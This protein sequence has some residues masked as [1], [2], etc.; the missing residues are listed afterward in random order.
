MKY[1][2]SIALFVIIAALLLGAL[3]TLVVCYRGHSF[4]GECSTLSELPMFGTSLPTQK[5]GPIEYLAERKHRRV[6]AKVKTT[7]SEFER[8]SNQLGLS[9]VRYRSGFDN[10]DGMVAEPRFRPVGTHVW[11]GYGAL[12]KASRTTI[13]LFF[14]PGQ[15]DEAEGVLYVHIS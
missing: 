1:K 10:N 4:T 2:H 6:F 3:C 12:G 13:R 9:V 15:P 8:L 5:L 11:F 7:A 14:E